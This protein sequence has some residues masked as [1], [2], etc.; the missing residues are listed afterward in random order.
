MFRQGYF[1]SG[2]CFSKEALID[3][4]APPLD[5]ELKEQFK[6][7]NQ[8]VSELREKKAVSLALA[9]ARENA[10]GLADISSELLFQLH[11]TEFTQIIRQQLEVCVEQK[12]LND[13]QNSISHSQATYK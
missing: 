12:V 1:S 10:K 3:S 13:G 5:Q 2:E 6:T 7:L 8:I 4:E 9:W 11:Y